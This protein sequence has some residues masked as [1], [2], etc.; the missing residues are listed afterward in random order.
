[1]HEHGFDF[2]YNDLSEYNKSKMPADGTELSNDF[3]D[4]VAGG[5]GFCIVAGFTND[6]GGSCVC[7]FGGG[8]TEDDKGSPGIYD[9]RTMCGCPLI[10]GGGN[11]KYNG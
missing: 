3:L 6:L 8:G 9:K 5:W 10:G 4:D 2:S 11:C 1:M 7:V